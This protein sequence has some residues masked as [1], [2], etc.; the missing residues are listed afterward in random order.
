MVD[1]Q[2][3]VR[4]LLAIELQVGG[5]SQTPIA[6]ATTGRQAIQMFRAHAPELIILGL[7]LPEMNGPEIISAIRAESPGTKFLVFTSTKNT[8]L[9]AAG[10]L[11]A[12][13]GFVHKTEP[14]GILREGIEAVVSGKTYW[15]AFATKVAE[16]MRHRRPSGDALTPRLRTILQMIAE[17]SSTKQVAA[18]LSISPKTVEHYRTQ[19]AQK[20]GLHDI[21]SLTRYAVRSG[22]VE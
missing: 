16:E 14:L 18:R 21:A 2:L 7:A 8:D 10:L 15:G 4:G 13:Q 19:L 5:W 17:G 9:L 6:S 20:L 22:I 3:A 11:T 1:D 12:P